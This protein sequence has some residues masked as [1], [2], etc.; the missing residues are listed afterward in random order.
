M[1]PHIFLAIDIQLCASLLLFTTIRKGQSWIHCYETGAIQQGNTQNERPGSPLPPFVI[2]V[3]PEP[4]LVGGFNP[5]EQY[6]SNWIMSPTRGEKK[7]L[8]ETTTQNII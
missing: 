3:F 5:F 1:I 8:F 4:P 6:L 2:G 7:K